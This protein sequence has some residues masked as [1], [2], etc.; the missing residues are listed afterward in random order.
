[1]RFEDGTLE[2][3]LARLPNVIG[4]KEGDASTACIRKTSVTTC[5]R[6]LM[7]LLDDRHARERSCDLPALI[8]SSASA[9]NAAPFQRVMTTET[10]PTVA[11]MHARC[12]RGSGAFHRS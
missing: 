1:M 11:F 9:M 2:L 7:G 5:A 6:T 12:G 3:K 10:S 4:I 8:D